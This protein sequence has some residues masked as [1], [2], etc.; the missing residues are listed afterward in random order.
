MKKLFKTNPIST[1]LEKEPSEIKTVAAKNAY[2]LLGRQEFQMAALLFLLADLD[3]VASDVLNKYCN[4]KILGIFL[5]AVRQKTSIPYDIPEIDISQNN[6]KNINLGL[7]VIEDELSKKKN[8]GE[9]SL[10]RNF[11]LSNIRFEHESKSYFLNRKEGSIMNLACLLIPV[12][13]NI[14]NLVLS[15]MCLG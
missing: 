6:F 1:L 5:L 14:D 3:D 4:D 7:I 11:K 2:V 15:R 9:N 13:F 12:F 8:M 10:S